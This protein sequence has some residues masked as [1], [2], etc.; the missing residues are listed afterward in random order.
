MTLVVGDDFDTTTSLD[1]V[2]IFDTSEDYSD[3]YRPSVSHSPY[4]RVGGT[5]I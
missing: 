1:T 3:F 4:A 5:Q 2:F